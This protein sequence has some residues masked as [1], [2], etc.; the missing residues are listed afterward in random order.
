M[1][2]LAF[3]VV[4]AVLSISQSFPST[5]LETNIDDTVFPVVFNIV[6]GISVIVVITVNNGIAST[7]KPK[8]LTTSISPISQPPATGAINT[9]TTNTVINN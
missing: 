1:L 8:M 2:F 9:P 7:G 6:L 4:I 5:N 3:F